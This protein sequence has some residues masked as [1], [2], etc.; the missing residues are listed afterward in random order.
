MAS[1]VSRD[2]SENKRKLEED[3]GEWVGPLPNEAT[4]TKKKK[5]TLKELLLQ[6]T[7]ASITVPN[8][9][10]LPTLSPRQSAFLAIKV[11][12]IVSRLSFEIQTMLDRQP[13]L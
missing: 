10:E 13:F 2:G 5:G 4:Q 12:C 6:N 9:S 7:E 3:E 8:P 11:A 1:D